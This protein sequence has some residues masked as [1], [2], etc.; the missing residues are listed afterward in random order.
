MRIYPGSAVRDC[1][2]RALFFLISG[3]LLSPLFADTARAFPVDLFLV[4]DGS[5]ALEQGRNDAL[6]WLCGQ[7]VDGLL[8]DGDSLTVW[9]AGE[10]AEEIYSG[11]VA[12]KE[13]KDAAKALIRSIPAGGESADFAGAL[14]EAARRGGGSAGDSGRLACALLISGMAAGYN[15]LSGG[16][17]ANLLRYSRFEEFPA[18]RA[19]TVAPGIGSA[20]KNAAA[21]FM[22]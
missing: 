4:I 7:V 2:R 5:A 17:M 16:E 22:R 10:K 19:V 6:D 15:S 12:G 18:W 11:R 1:R 20:V 8:R 13:T 14:R 9:A 3:C 21:A